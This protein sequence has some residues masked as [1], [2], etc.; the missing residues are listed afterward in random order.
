MSCF[1]SASVS[2][3]FA[4][5]ALNAAARWRRYSAEASTGEI[6]ATSSGAPH[7]RIGAVRFAPRYDSQDFAE[8]TRRVG[9]SAPRRRASSPATN[10]VGWP[11]SVDPGPTPA[12]DLGPTTPED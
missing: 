5:P 12:E 1:A 9:L 2:S 10:C 4:I 6:R 8:A 7:G 3:P 11:G